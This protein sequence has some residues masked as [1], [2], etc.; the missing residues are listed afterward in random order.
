[1]VQGGHG[2]GTLGNEARNLNEALGT[3]GTVAFATSADSLM[4]G[5]G[6]GRPSTICPVG[7]LVPSL[8]H[9]GDLGTLSVPFSSSR[10]QRKP[11][12][13]GAE[14]PPT[15]EAPALPCCSPSR[16]G[17]HG[18]GRTRPAGCPGPLRP[19][20]AW[21]P[22][23]AS[24]R[25]ERAGQPWNHW[26]LPR[27]RA[28]WGALPRPHVQLAHQ[29]G[30]RGRRRH[31][32]QLRT[33]LSEVL[34]PFGVTLRANTQG[35]LGTCA[36]A[37]GDWGPGGATCLP[38]VLRGRAPEAGPRRPPW[39]VPRSGGAASRTPPGGGRGAVLSLPA[40]PR[41]QLS[42]AGTGTTGEARLLGS[43]A[44]VNCTCGSQSRRE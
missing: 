17:W 27:S 32:Q 24:R 2:Q 31:L 23:P 37:L 11:S 35:G 29:R 40:R 14:P 39:S 7:P 18:T 12:A 5:T 20:A 3:V 34:Q 9:R 16:P 8:G 25:G 36:G 21:R 13:R 10:P 30:L 41:P 43:S 42:R 19:P 38:G 28:C 22:G 44:L 15:P 1:M 4:A 26:G 6:P 33:P